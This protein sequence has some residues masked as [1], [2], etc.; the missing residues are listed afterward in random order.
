MNKTKTF[1]WIITIIALCALAFIFYD[2]GFY[3]QKDTN[4]QSQPIFADDFIQ[5]TS[6]FSDG[7]TNPDS[8]T[9]YQLDEFDTGIAEKTIYY[10]DI[11]KDK[12]TDR[13]TKVFYETGNA[14]SYYT[15]KIELKTDNGYVEIS[16]D[17]LQTTN[18]EPCDLQQIQFQFNPEFRITIIYREM[19]DTWNEPT[20]AYK[21]I[22]ELKDNK[23]KEFSNKPLQKICDVK[24]LF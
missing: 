2:K 19:G 21:K 9:K 17:E 13:I 14:H 23:L 1:V 10:M 12:K 5:K 11:N 16:N 8:V 15:Y 6:E 4:Q 24:E 3:M 18:G 20:L 7:L 22:L